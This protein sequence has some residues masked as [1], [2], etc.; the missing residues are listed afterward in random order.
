MKQ[1]KFLTPAI[2]L[3]LT[4]S[5]CTK[6]NE[7]LYSDLAAD[8][9]RAEIVSKVNFTALL[10]QVYRDM[11][12]PF[13]GYDQAFGLQEMSSDEMV[14]PSR[15]SGWDNNGI[16][17]EM[18]QHTWTQDNSLIKSVWLNLNRGV[19]DASNILEFKPPANVAAEARFLRAYFMYE[20]VDL[21][22][23]LPFRE[24][25]FNLLEK[26]K[27]IKGKEAIDF[28]IS[29]VEAVMKDLP[30]TAPDWKASKNAANG[31]LT[32]LYL[33]RG[34]YADPGNPTFASTDLDK[35]I[36]HAD[37][38]TGKQLNFYW[39]NF[40]PNNGQISKE[41][42]FSVEAIG[43]T[44][45]HGLQFQWYA[46][47]P[48]EI[49]L[50]A[51]GGG[52]NGLCTLKEFYNK[53]E[54]NDIRRY[55]E[56][57]ITKPVYGYN[58]GFLVGQQY[59][60]NG[61]P[62]PNVNLTPEVPTIIGATLYN[63]IRPLKYI[64]DLGPNINRPDN[65]WILIRWADVLLMKAEALLRKGDEPAA[66]AIV[67]QIRTSRNVAAF[68]TLNLDNLLDERGRETYWEGMRRRDLIRFKKFNQPW[69]LKPAS[70][71]YRNVF[72]IPRED[73]LANPNLTQN[74]GYPGAR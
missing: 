29:E 6:L 34:V 17:R 66:R 33:N 47:L 51:S 67:N 13:P 65:D 5:S 73:V 46:T 74:P 22:N 1:I 44:R 62:I 45:A 32:R 10:D 36:Q 4:F 72:P 8:R 69:E 60:Q 30:A 21:F 70:Q 24:V 64:P 42:V 20:I 27:V 49:K 56:S 59:D 71:P 26:P 68:G 3:I 57:P 41:I 54:T 2:F 37:A 25:G 7:D 61:Q 39:D 11:D 9:A 15:P 63:G 12:N 52:W 19:F 23:Q 35:V 14:V 16:F 18:H 55:Y 50:S 53:Y 38:I 40:G 43:G 48:G 58:V 28:V 31:F